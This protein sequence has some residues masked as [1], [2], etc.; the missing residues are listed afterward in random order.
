[1]RKK[2]NANA[3]VSQLF[4]QLLPSQILCAM[5][6]SLTTIIN[7]VIVG[8]ELDIQSVAALGLFGIMSAIIS[9]IS[10]L[11]SSGARIVCGRHIGRGEFDKVNAAFTASLSLQLCIGSIFIIVFLFLSEPLARLLG[12][13][14][15]LVSNTAL[16]IRSNSLGIIPMLISPCLMSFLDMNNK[17]RHSILCSLILAICNLI[18]GVINI[19]VI[20]GGLFGIGISTSL[21]QIICMICLGMK[22]IKDKSLT[23]IDF[24]NVHVS[25]FTEIVVLGLPSAMTVLFCIRNIV[26]NKYAAMLGGED[27]VTALSILNTCGGI[28]DAVAIGVGSV[29]SMLGSV[30]YGEQD[31]NAVCRFAEYGHKMS[32]IIN[33]TK[34]IVLAL[35]AKPIAILF[36]ARGVVL[37]MSY[38][39]LMFYAI[40][41]PF[42][43]FPLF[44]YNYYAS[45][46][47]TKL[48]NI[49][50]L[51]ACFIFPIGSMILLIDVIGLTAVW[52]NF[53]V[54]E[55]LMILLIITVAGFKS[56]KFP[57]NFG[58]LL[59]LPRDFGVTKENRMNI[60]ITNIDEVVEISRKV[61][62]WAK[63]KG[64]DSKK[65]M[66]I[67]L[68]LEEMAA[69]IVEHGF[70]KGKMN[71]KYYIDVYVRYVDGKFYTRLRD[72]A[73]EF[74]PRSRLENDKDDPT[75]NIG[76]KMV[77]KIADEMNYQTTFG[78]NVLT[79]QI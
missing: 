31:R 37:D 66:M 57:T 62:E 24:S 12:A 44:M 46:G 13:T 56:K 54:A 6:G 10:S 38:D 71:K 77:N 3:L 17:M 33:G 32:F 4:W 53:L 52:S 75:K 21:A 79:I 20:K 64:A 40:T 27:A 36:G 74:N 61:C 23:K 69:N 1:M 45:I 68:C 73:P 26:L 76:I 59:F 50:Y 11:I 34:G 41:M 15:S 78:M 51:F 35:L 55:I 58:D 67:G 14:G 60:T 48:V 5:I 30:F 18:F 72:N 29:S 70:T 16:Y 25:T 22:F 47:K 49:Y 65:S 63:E 28:F 8:N 19:H 42:N 43:G 39:L 9:C 2:D 7:G